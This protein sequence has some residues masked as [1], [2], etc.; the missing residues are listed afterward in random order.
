MWDIFSHQ[1]QVGARWPGSTRS[2]TGRPCPQFERHEIVEEQAAVTKFAGVEGDRWWRVP[3]HRHDSERKDVSCVHT[4]Q[5]FFVRVNRA[6]D[7]QP[8]REPQRSS[9]QSRA[10]SPRSPRFARPLISCGGPLQEGK[11]FDIKNI[12]GPVST[13]PAYIPQG[14]SDVEAAAPL[15]NGEKWYAVVVHTTKAGLSE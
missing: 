12:E 14:S 1:F 11:V 5:S 8:P 9:W 7:R 15:Q 10:W 13:G 2:P 6:I 3:D 4:A